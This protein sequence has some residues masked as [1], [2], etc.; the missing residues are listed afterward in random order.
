MYAVRAW[1]SHALL[2]SSPHVPTMHATFALRGEAMEWSDALPYPVV[3]VR[4]IGEAGRCPA[5]PAID[6]EPQ[7]HR[8]VDIRA[9]DYAEAVWQCPDCSAYGPEIYLAETLIPAEP[10]GAGALFAGPATRHVHNDAEDDPAHGCC[11]M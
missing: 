1:G 6:G 3:D 8:F 7:G 10:T 5:R 11:A 2:T 4:D 9:D